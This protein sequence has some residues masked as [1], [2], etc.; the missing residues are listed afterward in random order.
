MEPLPDWFADRLAER[1]RENGTALQANLIV[2]VPLHQVRRRVR[3]L[4]QAEMLSKTACEAAWTAASGDTF[5]GKAAS[6]RISTF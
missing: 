4:H 3:G 5:A 6:S 2:P 1:V